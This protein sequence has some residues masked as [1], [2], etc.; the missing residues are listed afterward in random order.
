MTGYSLLL[1][2]NF[3]LLTNDYPATQAYYE[4]LSGR[5]GFQV[6]RDAG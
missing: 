5:P 1:A 2:S 6:A 4:R 3:G